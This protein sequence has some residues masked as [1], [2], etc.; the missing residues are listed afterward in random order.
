MNQARVT[1]IVAGGLLLALAGCGGSSTRPTT[2][3]GPWDFPASPRFAIALYSDAA[4]YAVGD[5]FDVKVVAYNLQ[6]VFGA[7]LTVEYAPS[8][9]GIG[10]IRYNPSL[11]VD[12]GSFIILPLQ[13]EPDSSRVSF[14]FT[15][16]RGSHRS[17]SGSAVVMRLRCL[18]NAVGTAN[19]KLDPAA[20]AIQDS[21]GNTIS[22]YEYLEIDSL[23]VT[24][25]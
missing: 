5:S 14:G 7:A 12:P 23:T 2:T 8:L 15:F 11:F 22:D 17:I 10:E 24:V 25:H 19:F 4:S 3:P 9:L 6:R 1:P 18:A 13:V 21:T 20:L 16:V